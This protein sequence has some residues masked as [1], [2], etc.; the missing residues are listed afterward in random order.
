M[1]IIIEIEDGKVASVQPAPDRTSGADAGKPMLA[2]TQLSS[3]SS[4]AASV[5]KTSPIDM[6]PPPARLLAALEGA[7]GPAARP[8]GAARNAG[9]AAPTKV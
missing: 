8:S 6:G 7:S 5:A 1:R 4:G 3:Q 2:A 9:P